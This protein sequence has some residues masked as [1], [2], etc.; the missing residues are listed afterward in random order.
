MKLFNPWISHT[1][2][3]TWV[4]EI[5]IYTK[6][7]IRIADFPFDTQCCE[8]NF[9][10]W[11]HTTKQMQIKQFG[12]KNITNITHLNF[13]TEWRVFHTCATNKT[14]VTNEDLYWWVASYVIYIKRNSMYHFFNLI[15]PWLGKRSCETSFLLCFE[16]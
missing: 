4:P 1:G 2:L 6:C 3:I 16:K 14:I 9:Y 7:L 13:N 5:R 10:S 15:M 11:A 8:I 12:N